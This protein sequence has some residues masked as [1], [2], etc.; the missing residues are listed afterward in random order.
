MA[1]ISVGYPAD[2]ASLLPEILSREN[3]DRKRR[4]L[5]ELFFSSHWGQALD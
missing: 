2:K 1:M 3:A 4:P 5:N